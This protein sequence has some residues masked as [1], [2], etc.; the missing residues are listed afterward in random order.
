MLP[1]KFRLAK[2]SDLEKVKKTGQNYADRLCGILIT[3]SGLDNSRFAFIVSN[4]ISPKATERNQ[5][6]RVLR[7]VVRKEIPK[8]KPGFDVL[9]LAKRSILGQELSVIQREIQNVFQKSGLY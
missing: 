4:K 6:K 5:I 3:K 2:R 9:F 7:E 1:K 8:I